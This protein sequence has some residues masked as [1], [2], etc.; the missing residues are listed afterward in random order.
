MK[1]KDWIDQNNELLNCD[2][3]VK[4]LKSGSY[5]ANDKICEMYLDKLY[6]RKLFGELELKKIGVGNIEVSDHVTIKVLLWI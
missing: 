4:I 2:L 3:L 5:N 1:L 6:A